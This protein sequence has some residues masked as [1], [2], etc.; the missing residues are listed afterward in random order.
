MDTQTELGTAL[1]RETILSQR[2]M[3]CLDNGLDL[4]MV[5]DDSLWE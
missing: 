1:Q 3:H 5:D 2:L 4:D